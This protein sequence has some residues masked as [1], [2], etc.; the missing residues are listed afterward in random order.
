[1]HNKAETARLQVRNGTK[2]NSLLAGKLKCKSN[3]L[4]QYLQSINPLI[5]IVKFLPF[6]HIRLALKSLD[7][8][9]W[10]HILIKLSLLQKYWKTCLDPMVFIMY[11]ISKEGME[12]Q[13]KKF[14]QYRKFHAGKVRTS[15]GLLWQ[16]SSQ[17]TIQKRTNKSILSDS[18]I[19]GSERSCSMLIAVLEC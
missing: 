3:S 19:K 16:E 13:N 4:L 2:S 9:S 10:M 12:F 5:R 1:M 18:N 11:S 14:I 15:S 8:L 6:F 7:L 17:Y